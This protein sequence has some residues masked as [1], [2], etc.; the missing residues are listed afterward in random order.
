MLSSIKSSIYPLLLLLLITLS[1]AYTLPQILETTTIATE[2]ETLLPVAETTTTVKTTIIVK[3]NT[4]TTTTPTK[5]TTTT[6]TAL[7]KSTTTAKLLLL[8]NNTPSQ[9]K[10]EDYGKSVKIFFPT[11]SDSEEESKFD[12]YGWKTTPL[13]NGNKMIFDNKPTTTSTEASVVIETTTTHLEANNAT[14]NATILSFDD[15]VG[16]LNLAPH[17]PDGFVIVNQRCHKSA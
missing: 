16:I 9:Q 8:Q 6:A 11:P 1:A 5:A 13:P 4:T 17:C 7:L 15:R 3:G 2:I 12:V 10:I 14:T